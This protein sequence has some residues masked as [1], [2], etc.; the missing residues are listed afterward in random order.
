[1][2]TQ[3]V[4]YPQ[5]E[6]NT[7][8]YRVFSI[9]AVWL[10]DTFLLPIRSQ[11]RQEHDILITPEPYSSPA[12]IG[13]KM[14]WAN[15]LGK[16]AGSLKVGTGISPEGK[17][18]LGEGVNELE[19]V[20]SPPEALLTYNSVVGEI[21]DCHSRVFTNSY[22]NTILIPDFHWTYRTIGHYNTWGHYSDCWHTGLYEHTS[23]YVYNYVFANGVGM[24]D[25]WYGALN[26]NNNVTGMRFYAF[27]L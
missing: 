4:Y 9:N 7:I 8:Q 16:L 21:I 20:I 15:Y 14:Q 10:S 6:D 18:Y 25:F 5:T 1:M 17:Y 23:N 19:M 27:P 11:V 3:Y 2:T 22:D 13:T 26:P 24:I 12:F